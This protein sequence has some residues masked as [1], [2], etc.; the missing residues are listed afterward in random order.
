[1]KIISDV[2]KSSFR[3]RTNADSE[4]QPMAPMSRPL[5]AILLLAV[6]ILFNCLQLVFN[7]YIITHQKENT[8]HKVSLPLLQVDL[9]FPSNPFLKVVHS[10]ALWVLVA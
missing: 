4:M 7:S 9:A 6:V 8:S 10:R 2:Q 3:S 1:M 5:L